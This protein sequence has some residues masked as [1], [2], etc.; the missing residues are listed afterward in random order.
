MVAPI[1]HDAR[2]DRPLV[3]ADFRVGDR[4]AITFGLFRDRAGTIRQRVHRP[5][6]NTWVVELDE[7]RLR[8]RR[9]RVAEHALRHA[10]NA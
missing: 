8:L 6:R 2:T 4:V 10:V 7:R 9:L 3:P 1:P 5:W